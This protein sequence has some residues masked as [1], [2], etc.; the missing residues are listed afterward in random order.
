MEVKKILKK[1]LSTLI[2]SLAPQGVFSK[3]TKVK[4]FFEQIAYDSQIFIF[5]EDEDVLIEMLAFSMPLT[6][7]FREVL[8]AHQAS[9]P[10][11]QLVNEACFAYMMAL[12][13][14]ETIGDVANVD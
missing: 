10:C 2:K 5:S 8:T 11:Y 12:W 4:D 6:R 1:E 13:G 14:L 7:A 9:L 3:D